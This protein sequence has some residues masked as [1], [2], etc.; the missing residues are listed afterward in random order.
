MI[1]IGSDHAALDMKNIIIE[2]LKEKGIECAD[3]GPTETELSS[4][5][6]YPIVGYRVATA[7]AGGL[8]DKGIL[9]CGTGIGM[10]I[11]ANKV[12]GIR[13]A[14]CS[15]PFSAMMSRIHNNCN[16]LALGARVIGDEMAKMIV[17]AFLDSDFESGGRHER[18][19]GLIDQVDNGQNI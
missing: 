9:I 8:Y 15:E 1:A 2:H 11:T 12:K 5:C 3:L 18:R 10:S 6:D 16:M 13:C 14:A 4:G 19:V 17:S 7:V